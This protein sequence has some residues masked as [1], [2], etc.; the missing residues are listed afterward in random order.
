MEKRDLKYLVSWEKRLGL[1]NR[2]TKK[3]GDERYRYGGL[4]RRLKDS[5]QKS[6]G[7]KKKETFPGER[8]P[9]QQ[10]IM[11]VRAQVERDRGLE[12]KTP[13]RYLA[14]GKIVPGVRNGSEFATG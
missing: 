8:R 13:Y 10:G 9:T 14:G 3:D 5:Y 2:L 4:S 12:W 1:G 11:N 6:W 7:Q